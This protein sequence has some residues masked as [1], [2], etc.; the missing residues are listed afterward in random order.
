MNV[1]NVTNSCVFIYLV[2]D[3]YVMNLINVMN[4]TNFCTLIYLV[5]TVYV[6]NFI[7]LCQT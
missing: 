7:L 1:M 4:V 6:I 5:L 3:V 2:P